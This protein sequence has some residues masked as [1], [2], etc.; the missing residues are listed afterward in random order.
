MIQ[1]IRA[2]FFA[3]FPTLF[4]ISLISFFM[5]R[6]I[7]GD[8]VRILLGTRGA[9]EEAVQELKKKMGL[10]QSL[11]KQYLLFIK[12][13]LKGDLG[14]SIVTR[15]SVWVEFKTHF[16]ATFELGFFSLFWALVFGIPMG[17]FAAV[18]RNSWIDRMIMGVALTGYS[19]PIFWLGL[20]FIL[21]FSVQMNITP[22]AGRL[23]PFYDVEFIT[24]F[25]LIDVLFSEEAFSAFLD[26]LW[27]LILPSLTLATIPIAVI[28]RMTRSSFLEVLGSDY[29]RTAR[30]KGLPQSWIL[31]KHAFKNALIPI[32]TVLGLMGGTLLTGAILTES[33]FSW[34]GLGRWIV[35]SVEARDYPVIQGGLLLITF[36]ILI[37]NFIVDVLYYFINPQMRGNLSQKRK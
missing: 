18:K 35:L 12:N 3:I 29:I 8:P 28:A 14:K 37:L 16:P 10:D 30:A 34:P 20:L 25:L 4:G 22:V 17:I 2:R 31:M 6:L 1:M 23:S 11:F 33:I 24:G 5:I 7:P 19:M 9:S 36:L 21:F 26:V 32:L 13:V 27:H 15:Q